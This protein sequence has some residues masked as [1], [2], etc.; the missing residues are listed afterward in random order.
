VARFYW[1][2]VDWL[3]TVRPSAAT[4]QVCRA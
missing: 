3:L 1:D 2:T 4:Y